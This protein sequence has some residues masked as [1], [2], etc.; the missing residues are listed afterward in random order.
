MKSLA[1]ELIE[2]RAA[3]II[4]ARSIAQ[5][6]VD[7][8]R[9]LTEGEQTAFDGL[10]A[11]A[12]ELEARAKAISDGEKAAHEL[13]ESFRSV[14]GAYPGQ[15]TAAGCPSLLVSRDN[16]TKHAEALHEG[17]VFGVVEEARALV[18]VNPAASS[19]L[20]GP[21]AWAQVGPREPM[22]LIRFAGIP[23]QTLTGVAAVMPTFTLPASTAGVNE[24]TAHGEYDTVVDLPLTALRYGR[25][26][27]VS[28]AASQF[29]NLNGIANLHS[30]GI[31]KDLDK[32][33]IGD[34]QT[35]AGAPVAYAAD[36][37]GNVR[38]S[39]LTVAANVLA[40]PEHLVIVGTPADIALLGDTTPANGPDVGSVAVRFN[41]ARMYATGEAN[42]G[43]VTIFAPSAF[44]VFMSQLQSASTI[45]P[46]DGSNS[47]GSWLHSTGAGQGLTGSAQAVEVV[48][49][50]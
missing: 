28:A 50:S 27:S 43:Q 47:F 18:Q 26:T 13:D 38:E 32:K 29:D 41:G 12:N 7:E 34:I 37:A 9:D 35:A 22:H 33:V 45:D 2:R 1:T 44:L 10:V 46:K 40:T 15:P 6:G 48:D 16:I 39:L 24:S 4:Q 21:Q 49:E 19:A 3:L 36:I 17:R 31:A 14:T 30:V 42:A 23:V 20:G 5:N 8:K 25:W 11:Q